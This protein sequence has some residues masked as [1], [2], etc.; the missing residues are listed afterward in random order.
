MNLQSVHI[1]L[2]Y[3]VYNIVKEGYLPNTNIYK[4]ASKEVFYG[5]L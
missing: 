4:L 5:L 3:F 2:K 1:L